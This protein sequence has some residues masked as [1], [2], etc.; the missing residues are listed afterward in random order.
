MD[1]G[2]WNKPG[3]DDLEAPL[4][5]ARWVIPVRDHLNREQLIAVTARGPRIGLYVPDPYLVWLDR[6]SG[7]N[8]ASALL[9]AGTVTQLFGGAA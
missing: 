1:R 8:L 6:Y 2:E 3:G 7:D 9:K 5:S 4:R